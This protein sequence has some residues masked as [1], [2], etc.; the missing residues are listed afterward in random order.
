MSQKR[1]QYTEGP[2]THDKAEGV[3]DASAGG[4]KVSHF[5]TS[6]EACVNWIEHDALIASERLHNQD[7]WKGMFSFPWMVK[8]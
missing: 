3:V 7:V 5:H 1:Q 8:L 6:I 2:V 4:G